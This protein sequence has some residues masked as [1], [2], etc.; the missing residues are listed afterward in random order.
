MNQKTII[1]GVVGAIIIGIAVLFFG[2]KG[3]H[4]TLAPN[5]QSYTVTGSSAGTNKNNQYSA[6]I[7]YRV[8]A[9]EQN[10]ITVNLTIENGIVTEA[11]AK[12]IANS[13]QSLQYDNRFIN[14][15]KTE[16]IGKKL[17]DINLSRVGGASL[18]SS[19]FNA[20]IANIKAQV[21]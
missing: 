19:A 12:N 11:D 16:V 14:S 13:P 4:D 21:G 2:L 8:P 3:D 17:S 7:E 20:A 1:V 6:T 15:Y 10:S 5:Q 18:T 9:P